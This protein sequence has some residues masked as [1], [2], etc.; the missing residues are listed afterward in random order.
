VKLTDLQVNGANGVDFSDPELSEDQ[1]CIAF[2]A[3]LSAGTDYFLPTIITAAP[4]TYERNIP[5]ISRLAREPEFYGAIRGIHLEGPFLSRVTGAIGA[6]NPDWVRPPDLHWLD[7]MQA[8]SDDF[9]AM[10]TLAPEAKGACDFIRALRN[11]GI[12]PALGH[13]MGNYA[14]V[15]DAEQAGAE[16]WTHF[17]NGIPRLVDRH[18]N[19]LWA[20]LGTQLQLSLIGDGHHVP[21]ALIQTLLTVKGA[22]KLM[23]V[24][25]ASPL[26]GCPPGDYQLWGAAVH[27]TEDGSLRN[28]ETGYCCGSAYSLSQCVA[29]LSQQET[30]DNRLLNQLA[31]QNPQAL[32]HAYSR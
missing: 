17:G 11:R 4:E 32:L 16:L 28:P 10:L 1:L 26:C 6:H 9:I 27:L 23:L 15:H 12:I 18:H 31:S 30:F 14:Q 24:S 29:K 2:R 22:A 8:L 3:I 5:L 25:D 21:V 20:V 13:S 7:Q 19:P